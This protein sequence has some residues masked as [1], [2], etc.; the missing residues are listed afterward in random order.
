MGFL[1]KSDTGNYERAHV[2][3]LK[4]VFVFHFI[5][6]VFFSFSF[7]FVDESR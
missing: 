1:W 4:R 6:K 5:G 7:F 3:Y 2:A